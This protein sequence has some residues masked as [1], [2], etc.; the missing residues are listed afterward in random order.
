MSRKILLV[1]D[2]KNIHLAI[3]TIIQKKRNNFIEMAR[4]LFDESSDQMSEILVDHVDS[5]FQGE[6]GLELVKN[7][8]E[9]GDPY[10]IIFLDM[11]M[12]P[13]WDGTRT[14][15][16]IRKVDSDVMLVFLT[17]Y[18]DKNPEEIYAEVGSVEKIF[19]L[20]KPFDPSEIETIV[21]SL[22]YSYEQ[23]RK[24]RLL[25]M[26]DGLTGLNN[27]RHFMSLLEQELR[28]S[29]RY[30][31]T[32]SILLTDIDHFKQFNDSYGHQLGD[33]VLRQVS[34][35]SIQSLRESDING[36]YG[37]E[38]FIFILPETDLQQA[39]IVAEKLRKNIEQLEIPWKKSMLSVSVSIG[40]SQFQ[41]DKEDTM[42]QL[43][44]RADRALYH[45]K[46]S[47]RNQ[48]CASDS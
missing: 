33:D 8:I 3:K 27:R 15:A 40:V 26:T 17:A 12:P 14:A 43:I 46:D 35:S 10:T 39:A 25:A 42:E 9:Q 19:Y 34:Q 1:D 2:D 37:G 36:R 6:E 47:G 13:G 24:L 48:V 4:N 5:A 30:K 20:K 21:T 31:R 23:E 18:S 32:L 22:T 44:G 28:K 7:A 11:R 41:P 45:A 29:K 38:E 16:E